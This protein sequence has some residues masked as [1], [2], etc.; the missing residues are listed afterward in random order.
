M[1]ELSPNPIQ[2][3]EA[4]N[5]AEEICTS[6]LTTKKFVIKKKSNKSNRG[7]LDAGRLD[8]GHSVDSA[9][10][11]YNLNRLAAAATVEM[12]MAIYAAEAFDK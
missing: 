6:A 12:A 3:I 9:F 1:A 7:R 2:N 8:G 5:R 4:L 10:C 11:S